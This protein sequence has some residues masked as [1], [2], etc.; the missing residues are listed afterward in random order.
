LRISAVCHLAMKG[1]AALALLLFLGTTSGWGHMCETPTAI[2]S[3]S[4]LGLKENSCI[5]LAHLDLN[6]ISEFDFSE[7]NL[8]F[9]ECGK[10][11]RGEAAPW[12]IAVGRIDGATC[13]GIRLSKYNFITCKLQNN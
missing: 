3:V 11:T 13:I 9:G 6:S 10:W 8:S 2:P 5:R 7:S 4:K 12:R 1:W